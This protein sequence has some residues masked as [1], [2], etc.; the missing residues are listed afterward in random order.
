MPVCRLQSSFHFIL[1]TAIS[2]TLLDPLDILGAPSFINF[3][4]RV[5]LYAMT[6]ILVMASLETMFVVQALA[7]LRILM[8]QLEATCILLIA[9]LRIFSACI[10]HIA[11]LRIL[12]TT[13][14]RVVDA[15]MV[16]ARIL[17][18]SRAMVMQAI[19]MH[20]LFHVLRTF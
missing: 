3:K 17:L 8:A 18:S 6:G 1:R 5:S 13:C 19:F 16:V 2:H 4:V 15:V 11:T 9:M 7:M 12:M 10:I 20:V 14:F